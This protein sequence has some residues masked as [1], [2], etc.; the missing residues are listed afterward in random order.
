MSDKYASFLDIDVDGEDIDIL[1]WE[2]VDV[3]GTYGDEAVPPDAEHY[4]IAVLV[5]EGIV[6]EIPSANWDG[7]VEKAMLEI[8]DGVCDLK[9]C[10]RSEDLQAA[11]QK[12]TL[13]KFHGCAV[14][15][16]IDNATYRPYIVGAQRQIDQWRDA[17]KMQGLVQH[18]TSVAIENPTLLL[19]FSA[20]DGNIRSLFSLASNAQHWPWPGDC[21]AYVMA[22][23]TI[24]SAQNALLGN[25]YGEQFAGDDRTAIRRSAHLRAFAKPLLIA[26][27]LWTFGAKLQRLTRL[28]SFDLS[29][30]MADWVDQGIVI[31]RNLIAE[32]DD[33][34]H[35]SFVNQ[36][37]IQVSRAKRMF[38]SGDD[39]QNATS[40]QPL[41][42][43][44]LAQM[45]KG[46]EWETAGIPQA[47]MVAAVIG[48]G[49]GSG[50]WS[51]AS[52]DPDD[53][54]SGIAVIN[55]AGRSDRIFVLANPYLEV[56]LFQSGRVD[57]N[58][59]DA[60]LIHVQPHY[61]R[62]QRTPKG[63]P[64]RTGKVGPR[65]VNVR[66]LAS[67]MATPEEFMEAFKL[68]AGV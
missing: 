11:P 49:A 52:G 30:E 44:S 26:L 43:V 19:G 7:L 23:E 59:N 50:D 16:R 2:G 42:P 13:L 21:P 27:V 68:E 58:D 12:A 47:A 35:A 5:K 63:A 28:G 45:A 48:N 39:P 60:V 9:V 51:V 8:N 31:L 18:L 66:C 40:Y 62:M 36:L 15:A 32:A 64:G 56:P 4:C 41:T 65:R 25:V 34:A 54:K 38:L 53:P 33:G 10:V 1:V 55:R 37:I 3:V 22:E 46:D 67:S 14:R 6:S 24:G 57:E 61:E 29:R 17:P 20:Q